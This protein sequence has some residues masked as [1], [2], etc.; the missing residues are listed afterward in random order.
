MPPHDDSIRKLVETLGPLR[1]GPQLPSSWSDY[2]ERRGLMPASIEEKRR[3]PRSYLRGVA[4]LQHRQSFP[5]LPRAEAWH[6][7]YTKDVCRGGIGFLHRQPLY[8]KEQMNLA[9]PDG[10]S[11]IV[12]VVRC[13]RI[14]PRCFEIGAIFATELRPLDTARSGD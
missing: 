4:A 14:Q 1:D 11:R 12:E 2:F 9:F 8:P 10:K 7:V 6:A 5:A 13:R 3:F